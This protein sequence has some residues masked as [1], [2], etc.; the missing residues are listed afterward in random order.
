[1]KTNYHTHHFL[2][3]HATGNMS[4]YID[5]AIKQNYC[6]L[7]ISDHGPLPNP[8]FT[9]MNLE[10]FKNVY[11]NEFKECKIKYQNQIKIYLGLEIE[12]LEGIDEYYQSL[13][14]QVDYLI[15]G[16]HYY[17]GKKGLEKKSYFE[18]NTP[19]RLNEYTELIEKALDT[20]CFKILA[21]PDIFMIGYPEFDLSCENCVNRI[22]DAA[23]RNHVLVE[24][25]ANGLRRG[26]TKCENG[27]MV[28]GY[29]HEQ[30]W[31]I[32]SSRK[33]R[34]IIG[35][36]C[37]SPDQLDDSEMQEARIMASRLKLNIVEKLSD[38]I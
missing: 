1:M 14:E 25:N 29:P 8:P 22:L 27:E 26:K 38:E 12:Y 19:E 7:G 20:K 32:V 9:R 15:L 28:Y 6:E 4:D 16:C 33:T 34:V 23:E 17:S 13:L 5:E 10:A 3:G 30:F 36:D 18:C 2:C 11:L 24:L 37:H 31:Q 35:S 21:H